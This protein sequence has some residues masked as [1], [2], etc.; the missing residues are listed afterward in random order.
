MKDVFK[1]G[2]IGVVAFLVLRWIANTFGNQNPVGLAQ[3]WNAGTYRTALG[4]GYVYYAPSWVNSYP[5]VHRSG[6]GYGGGRGGGYR[7]Q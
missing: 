6:S 5:P 2:I 7:Y 3:T 1:W 4:G